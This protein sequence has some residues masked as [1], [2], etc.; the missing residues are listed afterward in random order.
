[1]Q[2]TIDNN[3]NF[4]IREKYNIAQNNVKNRNCINFG[5][6]IYDYKLCDVFT[7]PKLAEPFV[8]AIK[9]LQEVPINLKE[10][11]DYKNLK[12]LQKEVVDNYFSLLDE[13][14]IT[15]HTIRL[16]PIF[17]YS[18]GCD[19][20]PMYSGVKLF[21]K[22]PAWSDG[23]YDPAIKG[24][25]LDKDSMFDDDAYFAV[26]DGKERIVYEGPTYNYRV[27][28]ENPKWYEYY[29]AGKIWCSND[30]GAYLPTKEGMLAMLKINLTKRIENI[31]K[32]FED[33]D[34]QKL[35][36]NTEKAKQETFDY[37]QA[38]ISGDKE[39]LNC[40]SGKFDDM[41]IITASYDVLE[42]AE[43]KNGTVEYII[44]RIL[45][46]A[47]VDITDKDTYSYRI[48][49]ENNIYSIFQRLLTRTNIL[50]RLSYEIK[51][52]NISSVKKYCYD[53]FGAR[54]NADSDEEIGRVYNE[55][56]EAIV[57]GTIKPTQVINYHGKGIKPIFSDE[58]MHKMSLIT[59]LK[60]YK[61]KFIDKEHPSG[62][63][64]T[65]VNIRADIINEPIELQIRTKP[66]DLI[67][68]LFHIS[69]DILLGKDILST[70]SPEEQK[71]LEP[72]VDALLEIKDNKSLKERFNLYTSKCYAIARENSS[73]FPKTEDY[74]LSHTVSIENLMK[75][76]EKLNN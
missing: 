70:Y 14:E 66:V 59:S 19:K 15:N 39:T 5:H 64:Y 63:G 17:E 22:L 26:I 8:V 2:L 53:I 73:N 18:N 34:A 32:S 10:I 35:R 6:V 44:K 46:K 48:K 45:S 67:A 52:N 41:R 43:K 55:L 47:G 20:Y 30:A 54:V 1:M 24:I 42:N 33:Y 37:F 12:G 69:Y 76:S 72:L 75:I 29:P 27:S 9:K 13:N 4:K 62:T 28:C 23:Y 56:L 38:L 21:A 49:G 31:C 68:R 61:T 36:A 50:P 7:S 58:Q 16:K 40:K 57:S 25:K 3:S 74:G 71:I 11:L 65:S 51:E 60:G